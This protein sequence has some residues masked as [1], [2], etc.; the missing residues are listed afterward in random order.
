[1]TDSANFQ[2]TY[3][4]QALNNHEMDVRELAP[5]LVA[6]ADL[7]EEANLIV[8]GG[9]SKI[10]VNVHGSFKSGSF[11]IDFTV[12]QNIV[13][14]VM[15]VFNSDGITAATNL[16]SLLGL[17]D[18]GTGLI[19]F[20]QKLK[21]KKIEK[22]ETLDNKRVRITIESSETIE[23]EGSVLDLYK[24]QRIRDSLEKV[25]TQPLSKTGIDEFRSGVSGSTDQVIVKKEDKDLF[26]LPIIEDEILG[27]NITEAYL[28]IISLSFKEDYKWKFSRGDA[29]F[30]AIIEDKNFLASVTKNEIHFSIDDILKV[31]LLA[32]D[33]LTSSGI[34]TEYRITE[35]IEHRSAARQLNLPMTDSIKTDRSKK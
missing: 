10:I 6:I 7:L 1:M 24:N 25:I 21:N 19:H 27:E 8:N 34:R 14:N 3:S 35:V 13:Q 23:V 33:S 18:F 5:A 11:G 32:K 16:L 22:V 9:G 28:Q 30:F 4:G 15:N 29:A 12:I 2:V 20:I 17:K 26:E 31:K